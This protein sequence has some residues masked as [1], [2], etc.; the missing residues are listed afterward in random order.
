MDFSI[1]DPLKRDTERF[2]AFLDAECMPQ[3]SKWTREGAVPRSFLDALGREGFLGFERDAGGL[4]E[5]PALKQALLVET[6]A[7]RSPGVA[8][9]V[10]VQVSLGCK[11]VALFGTPRQR[12]AYLEP[13]VRGDLLLCLGNT[14]S[15]AGSDVANVTLK[16][17]PVDGGWVLT[18]TKA[19]STNAAMS[20]FGIVTA[21]TDPDAPRNRRLSMFIVDLKAPGVSRKPLNKRVWIP[22]DLT[23]IQLENVFV[24]KDNLLGARGRGLQQV[25]EIFTNSRI[26]ISALTLGTAAGA[27]DLAIDH[28][29]RRLA[30]GSKLIGFQAK[31]FEAADLFARIEAARLAVYKA[32]WAKDSGM[33]FTTEA[34]IAKYL[35]VAVARDVGT[36]AADLFGAASVVFEHPVH[37]FPMDAWAASLGEGTQ[38][39]QKLIIYRALLKE[40]G[41]SL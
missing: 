22:S 6:L 23:R 28:G 12:E 34:S 11:S 33:D 13:G 27:F 41:I 15:H 14:E 17:E 16:A 9:V 36:W 26:P 21:V 2:S 10:L 35:T 3:L 29:A 20:D 31:G 40:R 24:P 19:Y 38:D 5:D 7:R 30:F 39:I 32:C 25:L 4:R 1:P 37:K 18:G 8:V